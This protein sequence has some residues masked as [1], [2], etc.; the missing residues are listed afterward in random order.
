MKDP[1]N[2]TQHNYKA[3]F[4]LFEVGRATIFIEQFLREMT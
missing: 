3:F 4:Q 2:H 1:F